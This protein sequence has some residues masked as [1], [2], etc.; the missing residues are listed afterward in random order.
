M[1]FL[2]TEQEKRN[3]RRKLSYLP[4]VSEVKVVRN[5]AVGAAPCTGEGP[6]T[7]SSEGSSA[8]LEPVWKIQ[9]ALRRINGRR[10]KPVSGP[11]GVVNLL[12]RTGGRLRPEDLP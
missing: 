5:V 4:P 1:F 10:V 7:D 2:S 11:P 9:G 8:W 6:L 3:N 12:R